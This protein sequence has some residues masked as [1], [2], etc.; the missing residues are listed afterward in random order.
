MDSYEQRLAGGGQGARPGFA[1][2][3]GTRDFFVLEKKCQ[4]FVSA[5]ITRKK[6]KK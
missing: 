5:I 4:Y 3:G 2:H 1:S 6:E